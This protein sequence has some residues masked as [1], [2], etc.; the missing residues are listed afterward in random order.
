[1]SKDEVE[2]TFEN[3]VLTVSGER[4]FSEEGSEDTYHRIERSYGKFSRS[5]VLP[6]DV[7]GS[8]VAASFKDG[9]LTITVPKP[10]QAQPKKIE[11]R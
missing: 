4:R 2:I 8:R 3:S 7:D 10:E 1:M 6:S 11:I 5:F 9:L